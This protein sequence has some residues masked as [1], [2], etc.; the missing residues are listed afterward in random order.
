MPLTDGPEQIKMQAV[1]VYIFNSCVG[2]YI[3]INIICIEKGIIWDVKQA[4]LFYTLS[5][6]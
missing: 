2:I 5:L 4:Q 6:D 3:A 1:Q